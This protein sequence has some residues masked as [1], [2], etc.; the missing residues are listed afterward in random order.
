MKNK[1]ALLPFL[2]FGIVI[3]LCCIG[4]LLSCFG[5]TVKA[6]EYNDTEH[7]AKNYINYVTEQGYFEGTSDVTFSPDAN[8]TRGMFITVLARYNGVNLNNYYISPF[9][10]ISLE[11][12]YT[13]PVLWG[14]KNSY[15]FGVDNNEFRP[16]DFLTREQAATI[17]YRYLNIDGFSKNIAYND[18][19]EVSDWAK[20]AVGVL[21]ESKIFIGYDNNFKPKANITRAEV[22]VLFS[23]LDG[24]SFDLYEPPKEVLT[25]IG[26]YKLSFYCS[27]CASTMTASG[28]RATIDKTVAL[29]RSMW[30]QWSKY[31]GKTIYIE[32]VGYRVIED[33]CGTNKFD[34]FCSGG[35]GSRAYNQ[36]YQKIYLVE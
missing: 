12:Y 20:E 27:G 19:T 29:P 4:I 3:F 30:G 32:N 5:E 22:A 35:C 11:Q 25:Y 33:K 9:K 2:L 7:W 14:Y 6:S 18:W 23:R 1:V 8:I 13:K 15:I 21:S 10:D 28:V 36:T 24:K 16:N 17:L 34:L 31:K 26:T